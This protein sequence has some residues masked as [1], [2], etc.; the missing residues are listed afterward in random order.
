[1]DEM[2]LL[3]QVAE[4]I[5]WKFGYV[6]IPEGNIFKNGV[7]DMLTNNQ[8]DYFLKLC[9]KHMEMSNEIFWNGVR[10]AQLR[11]EDKLK[12]LIVV[13]F[14]TIFIILYMYA[15]YYRYNK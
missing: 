12:I 2:T 14:S 15:I 5:Y 11:K 4:K 9:G 6:Y 1:M 13:G 10:F 7:G 3:Q 8:R